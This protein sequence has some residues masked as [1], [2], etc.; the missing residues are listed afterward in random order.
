MIDSSQNLKT[1]TAVGSMIGGISI[2]DPTCETISN[3]DVSE[4]RSIYK[5]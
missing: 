3:G 1:G 4:E 5:V 2:A